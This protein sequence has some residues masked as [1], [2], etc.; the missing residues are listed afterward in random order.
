MRKSEHQHATKQ[1]N[2]SKETYL[3]NI[4]VH[5]SFSLCFRPHHSFEHF[6]DFAT[7]VR[8]TSSRRWCVGWRRSNRPRV[9]RCSG[10]RG[11]D[12]CLWMSF[13]VPIQSR[14]RGRGLRRRRRNE[15]CERNVAVDVED[16][17]VVV[18]VGGKVE[19]WYLAA[20]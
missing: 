14:E 3:R 2:Q 9:R 18:V 5:A 1:T 13:A 11:L 19:R 17:S 10:D 6:T 15:L 12:C 16:E 4:K 8:L 20:V 7:S